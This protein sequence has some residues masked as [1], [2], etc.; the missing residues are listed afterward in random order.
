MNQKNA[1]TMAEYRKRRTRQ[2]IASGLVIALV[3][4]NMLRSKSDG[5]NLFGLPENL[6]APVF[7]AVV[8]AVVIFSL[9]NWRCPECNKYLGKTFNP[10]YCSRCGTQLHE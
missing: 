9:T 1:E 7:M 8:I 4:P 3:L 5:F 6:T 2:W 10:S